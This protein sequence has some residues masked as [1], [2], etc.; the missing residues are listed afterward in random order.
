M[1]CVYCQDAYSILTGPTLEGCMVLYCSS[2]KCYRYLTA[3]LHIWKD[4]T[5]VHRYVFEQTSEVEPRKQHHGPPKLLGDFEQL[6]LLRIICENTGMYLHE[7]QAK[8]LAAFGVT[9]SV[10]TICRTL[11]LMGCT[12]QVILL[13]NAVMISGPNLWLRL[14]YMILLCWYG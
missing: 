6:V 10:P 4:S 3:T 12:R 2:S 8:L 1:R 14:Q 11:K 7:I 13:C 9:V 5:K